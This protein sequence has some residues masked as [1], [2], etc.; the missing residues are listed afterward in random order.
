M[1]SLWAAILTPILLQ[2][3]T[4]VL[5]P[6]HYD[7]E[8]LPK[9]VQMFFKAWQQ[10]LNFATLPLF[11]SC[12]S[13]SHSCCPKHLMLVSSMWSIGPLVHLGSHLRL[14]SSFRYRSSLLLL[15]TGPLGPVS[16]KAMQLP[17]GYLCGWLAGY[18]GFFT[19]S[20]CNHG[21]S[22]VRKIS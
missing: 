18:V 9:E 14:P 15:D 7:Q 12:T 22:L 19:S 2:V 20:R 1:Y 21:N 6:H 17:T 11:G 3:K 8:V 5:Y 10:G 4:F 16:S 13:Y